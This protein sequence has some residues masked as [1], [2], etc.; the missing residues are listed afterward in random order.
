MEAVKGPKGNV[1]V[2]NPSPER[3]TQDLTFV[4]AGQTQIQLSHIRVQ[5]PGVLLM[6]PEKYNLKAGEKANLTVGTVGTNVLSV[7]F[8]VLGTTDTLEV[9]G[10]E[11]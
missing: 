6:G 3:L 7:E 2:V 8:Y 4:N 11:P 5:V 10:V 1:E 9:W